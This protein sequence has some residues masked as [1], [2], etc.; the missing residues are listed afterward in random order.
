MRNWTKLAIVAALF[1]GSAAAAEEYQRIPQRQ[2]VSDSSPFTLWRVHDSFCEYR[3]RF[4]LSAGGY[5]FVSITRMSRDNSSAGFKFTL[6][7]SPFAE[8][9]VGEKQRAQVTLYFRDKDGK[10]LTGWKG[11]ALVRRNEGKSGT[12][13]GITPLFFAGAGFASEL[14]NAATIGVGLEG[15]IVVELPVPNS[16]SYFL[17][18]LERCEAGENLEYVDG[19]AA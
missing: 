19:E 7:D 1:I 16:G 9:Q 11:D 13:V 17:A 15:K 2:V 6:I 4:E 12:S 8:A 14:P 3:S 18:E 10:V 5:G